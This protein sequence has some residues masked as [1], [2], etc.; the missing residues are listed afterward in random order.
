MRIISTL[1]V[2]NLIHAGVGSVKTPT[3]K[4]RTA[5]PRLKVESASGRSS[6]FHGLKAQELLPHAPRSTGTFCTR[7]LAY[8]ALVA[9]RSRRE[10]DFES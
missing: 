3:P 5:V 10:A 8:N 1:S 9:R 2:R 6:D 7:T 4:I